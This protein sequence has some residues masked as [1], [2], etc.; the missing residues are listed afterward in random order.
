LLQAKQRVEAGEYDEAASQL[1]QVIDQ[2]KDD[3]LVQI[4]RQRLARVLI[5]QG[6]HDE[7]IGLLDPNKAGAFAAQVREIRGDAFFAKGDQEAARAEYAA[8]LA[9]N[10]E[11]QSPDAQVDRS[12]LELKLQQVGGSAVAASTAAAPA[13]QDQP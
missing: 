4:T 9:P 10:A 13:K 3:E 7:A 11:G 12:L 2:A 6:K 1:R 8:A 5:Q